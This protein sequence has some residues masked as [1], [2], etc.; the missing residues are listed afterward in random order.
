MRPQD[1]FQVPGLRATQSIDS[2]K[3]F[4]M[5]KFKEH[6]LVI[7]KH[8]CIISILQVGFLWYLIFSWNTW[9]YYKITTYVYL[10]QLI[11]YPTHK[12]CIANISTW[13]CYFDELEWIVTWMGLT[14][15]HNRKWCNVCTLSSILFWWLNGNE[16][17]N[18]IKCE[19]RD[20]GRPVTG[21]DHPPQS[22][23]VNVIETADWGSSPLYTRWMRGKK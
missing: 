3:Y 21:T 6:F 16:W 9:N 19:E 20:V 23:G 10:S 8:V 17:V 11:L 18:W 12:T 2:T 15:V 5:L 1:H 4:D 14:R 22:P 13:P 7:N